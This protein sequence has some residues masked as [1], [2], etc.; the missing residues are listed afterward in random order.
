MARMNAQPAHKIDVN[1]RLTSIDDD[2]D[3][4]E[5]HDSEGEVG[6][7]TIGLFESQPSGGHDH[8]CF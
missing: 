7:A 4:G 2:D 1:I 3:A 6:R 8:R 5:V